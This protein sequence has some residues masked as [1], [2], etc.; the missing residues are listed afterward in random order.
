MVN[1]IQKRR[2]NASIHRP[3]PSLSLL[4]SLLF[5]SL[6]HSF[7]HILSLHPSPLLSF[8]LPLL[9]FMRLIFSP[10]FPGTKIR[11][12]FWSL[13]A[14]SRV[15]NFG[16]S[17]SRLRCHGDCT[18]RLLQRPGPRAAAPIPQTMPRQSAGSS[19]FSAYFPL[20]MGLVASN[21]SYILTRQIPPPLFFP[22]SCLSF[23]PLSL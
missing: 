9:F 19:P 4:F 15:F 21:G 3:S 7:I 2:D 23:L 14:L 10:L 1:Q 22:L 12:R 6:S 8:F 5:S 13:Q 11:F 17:S 16:G 18:V 20:L